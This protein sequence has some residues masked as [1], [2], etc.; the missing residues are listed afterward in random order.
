MYGVVIL[1]RG[2]LDPAL[3]APALA[4]YLLALFLLVGLFLLATFVLVRTMRRVHQNIWRRPA[5][6]TAAEDVWA[7][8][9]L[10]AGETGLPGELDDRRP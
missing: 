3:L 8:H 1:A 2:D 10:P 9:R 7:M 6:P 5:A 4:L